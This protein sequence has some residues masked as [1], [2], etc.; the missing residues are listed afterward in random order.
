MILLSW[1]WD[2][3][4]EGMW[5]SLPFTSGSHVTDVATTGRTD[6]WPTRGNPLSSEFEF[7]YTMGY[8]VGKGSQGWGFLILGLAQ[9]GLE[10]KLF[11][12][13][14]MPYLV[15]ESG[16]LSYEAAREIEAMHP[17]NQYVVP[18]VMNNYSQSGN[19]SGG[20]MPVIPLESGT[21]GHTPGI[22][23]SMKVSDQG[24]TR[25]DPRFGGY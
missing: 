6:Y 15:Y 11:G 17:G 14:W 21:F 18:S 25:G 19:F 13:V 3:F 8:I 24:E 12:K 20:S 2:D 16:R 23:E 4:T 9:W 22:V 1:S 10:R 7:D 5:N